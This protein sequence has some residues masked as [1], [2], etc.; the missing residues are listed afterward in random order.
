MKKLIPI[1]LLLIHGLTNYAQ[2]F[3][4]EW[5]RYDQVYYKIPVHSEGMHRISHSVLNASG[6]PINGDPRFFQLFYRGKQV[7]LFIFGEADQVF[8]TGDY[9]EFYGERNDGRIDSLLYF[10]SSV[11]NPAVNLFSDTAYYFLTIGIQPGLRYQT[12]IDLNFS[13]YQTSPYYTAR[14]EQGYRNQYVEGAFYQGFQKQ[15]LYQEGEGLGNIYTGTSS[16]NQPW[17]GQYNQLKNNIYTGGPAARLQVWAAGASNPNSNALSFDHNHFIRFGSATIDTSFYDFSFLKHTFSIPAADLISANFVYE[18]VFSPS[19]GSPSTRNAL[20]YSDLWIPQLYQLGNRTAQ[21]MYIPNNPTQSKYTLQLSGFNANGTSAYIYDLSNQKRMLLQ[22]TGGN[23]FRVVIGNGTISEKKCFIFS[24]SSTIKVNQI[25][26]VRSSGQAEPGKFRDLGSQYANRDYLI[27]S[28][29]ALWQEALEYADY[30]SLTGHTPLVLDVRELYDQF[31]YGMQNHPMGI[32]YFFRFAREKWDI[33]PRHIFLIGKSYYPDVV[34]LNPAT[35]ALNIIPALGYP[36]SDHHYV[37]LPGVQPQHHTAIGRLAARDGQ[38]VRNYLYKVQQHEQNRISEW[39]KRAMHFAGGNS[40]SEQNQFKA[41]LDDYA[42]HWED[43]SMVGYTYFFGK[44]SNAPYPLSVSDS[45]RYLINEGVSI[46]TFFGHASG[47]GFDNNIED[48]GDYDNNGKYPVII[49]NSCLSG[50]LF[51]NSATISEKFVLEPQRGS[52]AFMSAVGYSLTLPGFHIS[53]NWYKNISRD[54]YGESIGM[55]LQKSINDLYI[56][57]PGFFDRINYLDFS[58]HGDPAIKILS[59]PKPDLVILESDV[60]QSPQ[61]ISTDLDSFDLHLVVKNLGRS[62]SDS[63]RVEIVRDFPKEGKANAIYSMV[64]A[65]IQFSDSMRIRIPVD[66][67]NGQG[68]NIFTITVDPGNFIDEMNEFN[69]VVVKNIQINSSDILP[70]YPYE[71]AV[72]PKA[73]TH[74]KAITGDLFA[75]IRNYKLEIDTSALFASPWK[76]DT[77]IT[78]SGG[79]LNWYPQ[80]NMADSTVF[81]WRTGVDTTGNMEFGK[82]KKSSFQYIQNKRGWGQAD[83]PQF[84]NNQFTYLEYDKP[85]REFDFITNRKQLKV[86][87]IGGATAAQSIECKIDLDGILVEYGGCTTTPGIYV[88][89]IDPITLQPWVTSCPNSPGVNLNQY[90]QCA[91]C[92]NRSEGY[93]VFPNNATYR[94]HLRNALENLIPDGFYIVA[95]TMFQTNFSVFSP[96]ELNAFINLGADSIQDLAANGSNLPY[97]FF[98]RKGYPNSTREVVGQNPNAQISLSVDLENDWI[99][100]TMDSPLIGPASRWDYLRFFQKPYE[101]PNLDSVSVSLIGYSGNQETVLIP[102]L[103]PVPGEVFNLDNIVDAQQYPYVK[104]RFFTRDDSIRTPSQLR[105]WHILYEGVPEI[106]LNPARGHVFHADTLTQGQNIS[107]IMPIENIGDYGVDSLIVKHQ[108]F[109]SSNNQTQNFY[110]KGKGLQVN[111]WKLDTFEISNYAYPYLNSLKIEANPLDRN[112]RFLEQ[113]HFNNIAERIFYTDKDRINPIL[114]VTFDGVRIM[115]GD[116]VS[117][118]P[119][120]LIQLKDENPLMLLD[121]TSSFELFLK[122]PG[123]QTLYPIAL[124]GS[125]IQFFPATNSKNN[126]RLEYRPDFTMADGEYQL[127]LRGRD[128]SNNY[129]GQGDGTYDY[130]I[131]FQVIQ[132]SSI[133]HVFNYPNPFSTSTRFVFTL[134]GSEIPSFFKIQIFNINGVIVKEIMLDELGHIHIGDNITDYAWDGTDMFG[135]RLASGVYFYRVIT[136]INGESIE[137][138]STVADSFFKKGFGKMYLMR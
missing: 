78:Q 18:I 67:L 58:I 28:A 122:Y 23:N 9:I 113:L 20:M 33:K 100:G 48:P 127:L 79:I 124:H 27:I 121:D 103:L 126:A 136:E 93:F 138:R 80:L 114:D 70:V 16:V 129:S 59:W 75:P 120:I 60:K 83:F 35:A 8:N 109:S 29:S 104:L 38:D 110:K 69:N 30:R 88:A 56:S 115:D 51:Q 2:T 82:W 111:E 7:P 15:G 68:N 50:D 85:N 87:T 132:Q 12:E 130:K 137:K 40:Q 25:E 133:T 36:P 98:T 39:N 95:Y 81:Y 31:G 108:I 3:G 128:K 19:M 86:T 71:F 26:P 118:R 63:I 44:S 97:I 116:I 57:N 65:P 43:S 107:W 49:A 24:D 10:S 102:E 61:F 131:R 91:T 32:Y 135:N 76:K 62:I 72:V 34:R 52:I 99:F 90:N 13:S 14:V 134:T 22:N 42:S 46:M 55:A 123:S 66:A 94:N 96:T 41:F 17:T 37:Y 73:N 11:A 117:A 119:N 6:F 101:F 5:I 112:D 84:E 47:S 125:D 54:L 64:Q 105:F 92:R 77:I 106:A 4:N 89:V 45:I 1:F 21:T 74:L 53:K